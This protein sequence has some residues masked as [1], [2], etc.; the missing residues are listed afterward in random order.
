MA[1]FYFNPTTLQ[2]EEIESSTK[3]RTLNLLKFGF[4][5]ILLVIV[6][7]RISE[8]VIQS[9]KLMKL[10]AERQQLSYELEL[11]NR[12]VINYSSVLDRIAHNDDHLYRVFFEV[13]PVPST[14]REAGAGGSH[15]YSELK[16]LPESD[17]L[18]SAY[19]NMDKI[20][21]QLVIQS[22]SFDEVIDLAKTKEQRMA[23]KPSIQ[24]V[25]LSE[26]TR[27]GSAFGTRMHPILKMIRHHDGIDLTAPRGTRIYATADGV[28][29]QARYTTG[30]YGR[31]IL[32]DHGFGYKTLYGHCYK[33][34]VEP[35]QKVKR[36]EV[37]G[38]VGSTGLSAAPHLHYEVWVNNRPV[39]PINYYANDLSPEE[40]DKMINLLTTVDP[41]F[42]I[43]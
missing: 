30:G 38:L 11:L 20:S 31:K 37:I 6:I 1:K 4:L 24:P 21:R 27:F 29:V 5:V 36:G 28:V 10:I 17:L 13:E 32:I 8:D 9:P 7:F 43:N 12:S 39:D 40:Y 15:R 3:K 14:K 35:G 22:K 2:Y 18:V 33:I 34:L 25:S 19:S 23:A 42:D 26:L 41:S 16:T